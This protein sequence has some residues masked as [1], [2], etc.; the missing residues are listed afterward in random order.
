MDDLMGY[1]MMLTVGVGFSTLSA[2]LISQ[3]LPVVGPAVVA[4]F[5]A[6]VAHVRDGDQGDAVDGADQGDGAD[7]QLDLTDP[8]DDPDRRDRR[9]NQGGDPLAA[10]GGSDR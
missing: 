1:G 2:A 10:D 7:D 4:G 3:P 8:T 9:D 6:A 5:V